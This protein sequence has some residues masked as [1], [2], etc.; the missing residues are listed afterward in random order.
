MAIELRDGRQFRRGRDF[1]W[2]LGLVPRQD[3]TGGKAR[4]LGISKRGDATCVSCWST[5]RGL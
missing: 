4:L 1:A 3:S 2:S 5:G